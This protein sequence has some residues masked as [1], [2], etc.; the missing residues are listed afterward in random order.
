MPYLSLVPRAAVYN[1]SSGAL[2]CVVPPVSLVGVNGS[3]TAPPAVGQTLSVPLRLL[4]T[5]RGFYTPGDEGGV[6]RLNRTLWPPSQQ[7][8]LPAIQNLSARV[9]TQSVR[10]VPLRQS[11]VFY[12]VND[13]DYFSLYVNVNASLP[14]VPSSSTVV[15]NGSAVN[16]SG[17]N[18]SY[19]PPP[20]DGLY[21]TCAVN[22]T[23]SNTTGANST[24]MAGWLQGLLQATGRCD[25]CGS[26]GG[27]GNIS[28]G[29][30]NNTL[31][32]QVDCAGNCGGS[33]EQGSLD[34][35]VNGTCCYLPLGGGVPWLNKSA[36]NSSNATDLPADPTFPPNPLIMDCMGNCGGGYVRAVG[37]GGLGHVCC[38]A[39]QVDCMGVCLGVAQVDGC[40]SCTGGTSGLLYNYGMDC[41]GRCFP[42][43]PATC[44]AKINVS[45]TDFNVSFDYVD[46]PSVFN[47]KLYIQNN[48][49]YGIM[50]IKLEMD[51]GNNYAPRVNLAS[52]MSLVSPGRTDALTTP[53]VVH[54]G[55]ILEVSV[56]LSLDKVFSGVELPANRIPFK[57]MNVIFSFFG[58]SAQPRYIDIPFR[59]TVSSCEA[60]T[61]SGVCGATP[62]CFYCLDGSIPQYRRLSDG[63]R[64]SSIGRKRS[65][66]EPT[67]DLGSYPLVY[68]TKVRK[69]L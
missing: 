18:S 51:V 3:I 64:S 63:G 20:L 44:V 58:P 15:V 31:F 34:F 4:Y 6:L 10:V 9:I 22:I 47:G 67:I 25:W 59:T 36:V 56:T 2:T 37:F 13:S 26:C 65:L 39:S 33:A 30:C 14:N 62:G 68:S 12:Y 61:A 53:F 32:E 35:N 5:E 40:G 19:T 60:I 45:Q 1:A 23:A 66:K 8:L 21:G 46:G 48:G 49:Y 28:C 29:G 52:N 24:A 69:L 27:I 16:G 42:L 50:I 17:S 11:M 55:D 54:G 57:T 43:V 7:A 41:A 38:A